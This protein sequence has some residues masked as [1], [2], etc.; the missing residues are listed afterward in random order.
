MFGAEREGAP[1]VTC[2]YGVP[3]FNMATRDKNDDAENEGRA[4]VEGDD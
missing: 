3:L 1:P 2:N 4:I